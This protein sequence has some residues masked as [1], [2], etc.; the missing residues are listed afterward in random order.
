MKI[1]TAD[2]GATPDQFAPPTRSRSW[3]VSL[4]DSMHTEDYCLRTAMTEREAR[5]AYRED[6]S[7]E[8]LPTGTVFYPGST[9]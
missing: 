6:H 2:G 9:K 4:P 3:M 8:R 1:T 7:L 5:R